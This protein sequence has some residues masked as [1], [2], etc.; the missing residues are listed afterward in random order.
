MVKSRLVTLAL[1]TLVLAAE[2]R[3]GLQPEAALVTS[4]RTRGRDRR[5]VIDRNHVAVRRDP[6]VAHTKAAFLT[7]A[8]D[9]AFTQLGVE[10]GERK[11][12]RVG[13][14]VSG[15]P[16]WFDEE[17]G[18]V[19]VL[20]NEIV[21][22]L[23]SRAA[24]RRLQALK[25]LAAFRETPFVKGVYLAKFAS[26]M[27]A[28]NGANEL[29]KAKGVVWA[30][31]NFMLPKEYRGAPVTDPLFS[32][33]WN[34]NLIEAPA[35]W[36][37]TTGSSDVAI[38]VL[39]AG[40]EVA[41]PDMDAAWFRNSKEIPGN[42]VDD[43]GNGY[44]DDVSGWNFWAKDNDPSTGIYA[45]HGITVA[46][47]AGARKNGKGV[48]GVCP[49]CALLPE[50]LD[51][52]PASDAEAFYYAGKM[53]V[54]IISNSWGYP[55]G[56]P[57]MDFLVEAIETVSVHGRGGKGVLIIF[58]MNN[59]NINDCAGA[60]PDV[61]SLPGAIAVSAS[62]DLDKKVL[63][64]AWGPCME[65]LA[66]SS[67][68]DRRSITTTDTTGAQGWNN[69]HNPVDLKDLDYTSQFGGTSA[70]APTVAGVFGLML[71]VNGAL[72]RDEAL[73]MLEATADKIDPDVARYDPVTGF[74]QKYGYGRVNAARAVR[75]AEAYKKYT[76]REREAGAART[77][78]L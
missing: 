38:A 70:S 71:S 29:L 63:D 77:T 75:A 20:T 12:V 28:L 31:P 6:S 36:E 49:D 5:L 10:L 18:A 53:G 61:S 60:N 72:T 52:T 76:Q 39:D 50:S 8:E 48:V 19:G 78:R 62:S 34:L 67:E 25:G 58:A 3:A 59:H 27:A 7:D 15:Y 30:H 14:V 23:D 57:G 1:G 66:P 40:F 24:V 47:I 2:A 73:A 22:R 35:A 55:Q 51:W 11:G 4:F 33:Q 65:V 16:V 37:L 69:G 9:R 42:G 54:P 44:V 45:D 43:D 64:A 68:L 56:I 13:T 41:H 74:S 46:G 32:S 26:P 21:A 17:H